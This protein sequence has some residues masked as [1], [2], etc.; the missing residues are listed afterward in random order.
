MNRA[1]YFGISIA[2]VIIGIAGL[3]V[4]YVGTGPNYKVMQVG[5]TFVR[6]DVYNCA[7]Y[8]GAMTARDW[9]EE[10]FDAKHNPYDQP[11]ENAR[12]GVS[13]WGDFFEQQTQSNLKFFLTMNDIAAK[14]GYHYSNEVEKKIEQTLSA[15][16]EK[17]DTA[18][19]F[20]RFMLE[21][22]GSAIS[23]KSLV[24]YLT[25][26]YRAEE[27]YT[28]ITENKSQFFQ[29]MGGDD[30]FFEEIYQKYTDKIDTVSIRY[31]AVEKNE[32]NAAVIAAL[33]SAQSEKE[34][35]RLCN[36]FKNDEAYTKQDSSL[37]ENIS[38]AT[39]MEFSDGIIAGKLSDTNSKAG[40]IIYEDITL[41]TGDACEIVY[42][43]KAR[44]KD[45]SAYKDSEVKNW[46]YRVMRLLLDEHFEHNYTLSIYEKG[47]DSFKK[48][49]TIPISS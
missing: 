41:D 18:K 42:V 4:W 37:Y 19:A 34:F 35:Q 39:M 36:D 45:T 5:D 28:Q 21:S 47:K 22:Y 1:A 12:E 3:I 32:K 8:F 20:D 48:N 33:K 10:G 13:N 43:V 27:F 14:N 46:E 38:V 26:Q 23:K 49:M 40:D 30:A 31:I 25:L 7:Y 11:I 9:S 29:Y 15:L 24:K 2:C 6:R 44:S 16:E 17:K